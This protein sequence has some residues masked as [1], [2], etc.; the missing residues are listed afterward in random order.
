LAISSP[1]IA[2]GL[3]VIPDNPVKPDSFE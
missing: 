2:T 3:A 1:T